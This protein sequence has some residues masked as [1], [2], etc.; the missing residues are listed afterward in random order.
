MLKS[1]PVSLGGSHACSISIFICRS[2]ANF[3]TGVNHEGH[4]QWWCTV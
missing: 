2:S 3:Q 1:L 4:A